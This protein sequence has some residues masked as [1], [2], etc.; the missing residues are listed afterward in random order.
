MLGANP[1]ILPDPPMARARKPA[2]HRP[3][4]RTPPACPL[5]YA[6]SDTNA[7][8]YYFGR[9]FAPDAYLAFGPRGQRVAVLNPLEYG[10][11]LKESSYDTVLRLD[12]WQ[13]KARETFRRPDTGIAHIVK[14]L[15]REYGVRRFIVPPEF[16][17]GLLTKL[18]ALQIPV[19]VSDGPLFPERAIKNKEE[20][21][22]VREGCEACAAGLWRPKPSAAASPSA[23]AN[24]TSKASPSPRKPCAFSWMSPASKTA[25]LRKTPLSLAASRPATRTAAA[26]APCAPAI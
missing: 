2:P 9:F 19:E 18:R 1:R 13:K 6:A 22:L 11:A 26:P 5:L 10:R 4:P 16:P 7:D 14:L 25:P 8:Q 15:A 3:A 12:E 20:A 17:A 21:A 24:S 23:T